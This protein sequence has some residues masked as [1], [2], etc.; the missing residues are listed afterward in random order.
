VPER[1]ADGHVESVLGL[2]RD[3]TDH[4]RARRRLEDLLARERI[5][6]ENQRRMEEA[7]RE[8]DQRKDEFLAMLAHEL[9]NPL[10]AIAN[11]ARVIRGRMAQGRAADRPLEIL[12]RQI[13]NCARLLDDLLD[14][15]RITRGLLQLRR[16]TVALDAVLQS[17][18]DSQ[19][20]T[21]DAAGHRLIL[22]MP[23][24]PILLEVDP[25]RLEQVVANLLDN[26][27][28]YT[29][30]GGEIELAA[31]RSG[32]EVVVRVRDNGIGIPPDLLPRVFD[33]FV[34]EHQSLARTQ[35]GLGLGLTLV[36][37]L[38]EMHG[39]SVE[40][41]SPGPGHGSV[42]LVRLPART[43]PRDGAATRDR[44]VP[45]VP[46]ARRRI[47]LV[48]DN[49]DAAEV[50]AEYLE[51]LGHEVTV[52]HDGPAALEA[53]ARVHP[54][55]ALLDIGLPGMDGYEVG[56]R[57]RQDAGTGGP[58]LVALTGYGQEED[59]KRSRDSGFAHHLTKPF[60]AA[61]LERLLAELGGSR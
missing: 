42:F 33:L 23:Q 17:A 58:V 1:S 7:L 57:L 25:T 60:E 37:K 45:A 46:A 61:A 18:V 28:K 29:P 56:R 44:A 49:A 20:A 40:A 54:E 39:G 41:R 11:A 16:E 26:A 27:A 30:R 19:R 50:L 22:R 15:S 52:A 47:L 3:V 51:S 4:K 10:G 21:I 8:A 36:R 59:R 34:Q 24:P 55:I 5:D 35:G 9:R 6:A 38:V 48:E 31:E 2:T 13:G 43:E 14:V 32:G 53:A 12:E